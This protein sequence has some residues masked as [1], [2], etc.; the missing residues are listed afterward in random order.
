MK[1]KL[2][3]LEEQNRQLL[4]KCVYDH[5]LWFSVFIIASLVQ[6]RIYIV[7]DMLHLGNEDRTSRTASTSSCSTMSMVHLQYK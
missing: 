3:E 5:G 2:E 7:S 6:I 4:S 1:T